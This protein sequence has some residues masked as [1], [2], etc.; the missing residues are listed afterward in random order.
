MSLLGQLKPGCPECIHVHWRWGKAGTQIVNNSRHFNYGEPIIPKGSKQ[1]VDIA[2][3]LYKSYETH[4]TDYA[5][6]LNLEPLT[7][8]GYTNPPKNMGGVFWYSGKSSRENDA[9]F[10]HG[11]FFNP[12]KEIGRAHV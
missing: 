9:G 5:S 3:S 4:P 6:V 10:V 7:Y 12:E 11:G 8:K 2:V 1:N